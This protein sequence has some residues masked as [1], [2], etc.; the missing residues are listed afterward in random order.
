MGNKLGS[1]AH[2]LLLFILLCSLALFT[3]VDGLIRIKL[4]K[5]KRN[6]TNHI[7]SALSMHDGDYLDAFIR[8]YSRRES[9]LGDYEDSDT[10]SLTDYRDAQYFGEIGIGTPPQ[11]FTVIFD[12][13][14]ANLWVPS[15]DCFSSVSC[16]FHSKYKSSQS[17]TYKL[18]GKPATIQYGDGS[19]SGYFGEDT[20]RVADIVVEDQM[21]IEAIR[22]SDDEIFSKAKFDGILGLGFKEISVGD[23]IPVWENMVD[24]YLVKERVFSFWLSGKSEE[25]E[26]GE[27]VF[28][29]VDPYHYK[30]MHTYVPVTKT[31]YWQF[32]MDDVLIGGESNGFCEGGCSAIIDSGTSLIAGPAS[33]INQINLA[34]RATGLITDECKNFV[35]HFG[36]LG[37]DMVAQLFK[38][39]KNLCSRGGICSEG[40]GSS[41]IGIRSVVDKSNRLSASVQCRACEIILGWL[42]KELAENQTRESL[43]SLGRELCTLLPSPVSEST[44]DCA[45]LST[46]PIVS[47][48]IGGKEFELSP[49]DYIFKVGKGSVAQCVTGFRALDIPPPGGPLWI[50]G[51]AFMRRYHTIFDYD[52]LRVG[53]AEAA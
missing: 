9:N 17:S 31:G 16:S 3:P 21:F 23:A 30:G 29:G 25:G 44:V 41:S 27:I 40:G 49:H 18:N 13:G 53:F 33:V 48:K 7:E 2:F 22:E 10:V 43:F 46:M 24:Q 26:G 47:F 12:T 4:K 36:N 39:P 52:F 50:L 6:E 14:S 45:K 1:I 38:D 51:D 37:F 34:I 11:K 28:G 8:K 20:V 15:A 42:H 32:Y 35:S 19:I 5:I